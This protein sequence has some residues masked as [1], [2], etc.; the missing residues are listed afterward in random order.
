MGNVTKSLTALPHACR[1]ISMRP[2]ASSRGTED[3]YLVSYRKTQLFMWTPS[4]DETLSTL[5]AIRHSGQ[6]N[7]YRF[8]SIR[9]S[10]MCHVTCIILVGSFPGV[11]DVQAIVAW[12]PR[13]PA[14]LHTLACPIKSSGCNV[15][16]R[17]ARHG[18]GSL[19]PHTPSPPLSRSGLNGVPR[20][21]ARRVSQTDW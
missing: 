17:R 8:V 15:I 10:L 21:R 1:R 6:H 20:D 3:N 19:R 7:N 18:P 5:S 13:A 9:S 14:G 4:R 11:L 2:G 12:P 16:P